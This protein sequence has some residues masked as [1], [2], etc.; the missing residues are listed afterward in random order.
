MDKFERDF[1]YK[2]KLQPLI[3][4][5]FLDDC[6]CIWQHGKEELDKFLEYLNS[7]VE[8]IKFTMEA[9]NTRV[10]FLDTYISIVNNNLKNDLY[11]KPTDSYNYLLYSSAHPLPCKNAIPYSQFLRIRTI[12]SEIVD[13]DRHATDC[14]EYFLKSGYSLD[15]KEVPSKPED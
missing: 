4:K 1:V 3:W 2:Y 11:C 7:R 15:L 5:R 10:A 8:S 12:C 14:A 9:S 13:F 6:F